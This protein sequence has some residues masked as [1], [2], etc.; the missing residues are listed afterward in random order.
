MFM[1][2][3]APELT[4]FLDSISI[5]ETYVMVIGCLACTNK[6]CEDQR[7]PPKQSVFLFLILAPPDSDFD[8]KE[9]C[10]SLIE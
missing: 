5:L 2:F 4:G 1:F 9:S 7:A 10:D 6:T 8:I 3:T